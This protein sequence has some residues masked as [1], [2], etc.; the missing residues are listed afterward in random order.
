M[1]QRPRADGRRRRM[2]QSRA[3]PAEQGHRRLA[4]NEPQL[5]ERAAAARHRSARSSRLGQAIETLHHAPALV[6]RGR[7]EQHAVEQPEEGAVAPAVQGMARA[8]P[9]TAQRRRKVG[10]SVARSGRPAAPPRA[11]SSRSSDETA[12]AARPDCGTPPASLPEGVGIAAQRDRQHALLLAQHA[13]TCPAPRRA[14]SRRSLARSRARVERRRRRHSTVSSTSSRVR[15][16]AAARRRSDSRRA[17]APWH[18]SGSARSRPCGACSS[19]LLAQELLEAERQ[20]A[21]SA[22]ASA[23]DDGAARAACCRRPAR[24]SRRARPPST[25]ASA[26]TR[27]P[28]PPRQHLR[29]NALGRDATIAAVQMR[30]RWPGKAHLV[31]GQ[32]CTD[33]RRRSRH[34]AAAVRSLRG[35]T[36]CDCRRAI[37][38]ALQHQQ[39]QVG[40][41]LRAAARRSARWP[42]RRRPGAGR[43]SARA[44]R[45]H[46]RARA[47][48][49]SAHPALD[50]GA[51]AAHGLDR[52]VGRRASRRRRGRS[53]APSRPRA[54]RSAARPAAVRRACA[55]RPRSPASAGSRRKPAPAWTTRAATPG[56]SKAIGS[57]SIGVPAASASRTVFRPACVMTTSARASS[58]ALRCEVGHPGRAAAQQRAACAPSRPPQCATSNC[59]SSARQARAMRRNRLK[60]PPCNVPSEAKTNGRSERSAAAR[61]AFGLARR[62]QRADVV[63]AARQRCARKVEAGGGLAHLQQ[64]R[65]AFGQPCRA[66]P[67]RSAAA[68]RRITRACGGISQ[69]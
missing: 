23:V 2:V 28:K 60:R 54:A 65:Q 1:R 9:R 12:P 68:C 58:C 22:A 55:Q 37:A 19:Q 21:C 8:S 6:G 17:A 7:Q 33:Q 46:R 41:R 34:A 25:G 40:T 48:R 29:R 27:S 69:S 36:R 61:V 47:R 49:A 45:R 59:T 13:R 26:A 30:R 5:V 38:P 42:G 56:W 14:R 39:A 43:A 10:G 4:G 35:R 51:P 50:V 31:P 15:R 66:A 64:R 24:T 44:R 63:E 3:Q 16:R 52:S 20:V 18:P 62:T 32:R 11:A 57:A 67:G 53:P